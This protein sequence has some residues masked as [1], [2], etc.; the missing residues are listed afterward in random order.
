M[1]PSGKDHD[2]RTWM[3]RPAL[4]SAATDPSG[5]RHTKAYLLAFEEELAKAVDAAALKAAMEARFPGLGMGIALDIGSKVAKGEMKR[6]RDEHQSRR[7]R[8]I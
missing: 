2:G 6:G 1:P 3:S 4:I 8:K 5:V 7:P